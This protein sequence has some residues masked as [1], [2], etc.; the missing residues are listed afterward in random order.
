MDNYVQCYPARNKHA[1]TFNIKES[2]L[3][4]ELIDNKQSKIRNYTYLV[5]I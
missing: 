4:V 3:F 2:R 5:F 1:Y